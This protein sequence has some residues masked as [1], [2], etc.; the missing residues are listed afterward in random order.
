MLLGA[1]P[2]GRL[3]ASYILVDFYFPFPVTV[4]PHCLSTTFCAPFVGGFGRDAP[5]DKIPRSRYAHFCYSMR[6]D[7]CQNPA[8]GHQATS[9]IYTHARRRFASQRILHLSAERA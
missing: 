4:M 3:E 5:G 9:Y 1:L 6:S 8:Y 7:L 2:R